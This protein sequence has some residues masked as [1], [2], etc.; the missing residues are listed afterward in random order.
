M[1]QVI[2]IGRLVRLQSFVGNRDNL[3]LN[4]LYMH[5]HCIP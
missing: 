1:K 3:L 5:K 4:S 2:E